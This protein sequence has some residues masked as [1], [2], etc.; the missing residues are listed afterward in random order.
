MSTFRNAL[1]LE[2]NE[3]P[4]PWQEELLAMLVA[5]IGN[6]TSL[7]I[8]TGLGKTGV[9]AA[10]LVARSRGASVPRRLIYFVDRR[11]VVDQATREAERLRAW[12][13]DSPVVKA[14]LGLGSNQSLP[15][16]TLRGRYI[17]NREWLED[18]SVPA[19]VVGTVDMIGSRLFFEGYGVS[20]KMRPYHAALLGA[21]TLF[22]LDEA[23]LVPPFEMALQ[24]LVL[25]QSGFG[26]DRAL[27]SMVPG[28]KLLSL[29][30]TGRSMDGDTLG[31]TNADLKH[32]VAEKRLAAIKRLS[33][34]ETDGL[35]PLHEVLAEEAWELVGRGRSN[36]RV[37][38][39]SN[40][41]DDAEKTLNAVKQLANGDKKQGIEPVAIATELFVGARRVR[42]RDQAAKRLSDHGFLARNGVQF[43]RPA[44]VFATSAGEVGVDLDAGHMVC[45]LVEWERMVQRLG[46][47]NRRGNG[48]A[49][50]RVVVET[51]QPDMKTR[52]AIEQP[53]AERTKAQQ[54]QVDSFESK[55]ERVERFRRPVAALPKRDGFHD[56]SPGALRNLRT[57]AD[58]D[59]CLAEMIAA[60]T[61]VPPLRPALT[62]PVVDAWSMTSLEKHTGRPLVAPWLRGW[63]DALPQTTLVW[64][65]WLPVCQKSQVTEKKQ[66][67][68]ASD[69]FEQAPPH[70]SETL[71]TESERVFDWLVKRAKEIRKTN[72]KLAKPAETF[73]NGEPLERDSVIGIILNPALDVEKLVRLNQLEFDGGDKKDNAR[74]K[75][76]LQRALMNNILVLDLRF[77]GLSE[78]GLLNHQATLPDPL[79]GDDVNW[80]G[81]EFRVRESEDAARADDHDW[82]TCF[83]FAFRVSEEGETESWLLVEKRAHSAVSEDGRSIAPRMQ[84]LTIHQ[85]WAEREADR[86]GRRLGL[87]DEFAKM[88]R[89]VAR[90]HDE[91]KNAEHWQRAFCAPPGETK[92][93]KTRGPV[94]FRLLGGYRHEFGSLPIVEADAEFQSL[95]PD[96]KELALHLVAAHHGFARPLIRTDGCS[97]GPPSALEGRAR[98]VALR[99][100]RLQ[101]RWGPWGLAWW[102]SLLRASDQ[103][104][105]REIETSA[106]F[107]NTEAA[108]V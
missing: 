68:E 57:K 37:I 71:E 9:M 32:P 18:P 62:R 92:Y 82:Q 21:D 54:K 105:S 65:R 86:L 12:V 23:H 27:S 67:A 88:L 2:E 10:W 5:G 34:R 70:L 8:P 3:T 107:G 39:Y 75:E 94:K 25:N 59:H 84:E 40:S 95:C 35:R 43:D 28:C 51:P 99:F 102:E 66:C 49:A 97:D 56:A 108:H 89:V 60:A 6:G 93:A 80:D 98:D 45:D 46:R 79:A 20:R 13:D 69:F 42:E 17:D 41:R 96:L 58:D 36:V 87:P 53:A 44:L 24:T 101:R 63:V 55:R 100:A 77:G 7:D 19:I 104:A 90:L 11:A 22:V 52:E 26:P 31:L 14:Q 30:A 73:A 106:E 61:S 50:I 1:G 74:Q 4:F 15:I 103:R 72:S 38:V 64:R 85:Q 29:S 76:R 33:F 91:G 78:D 48:M 47:V 16:S 83:R 81:T